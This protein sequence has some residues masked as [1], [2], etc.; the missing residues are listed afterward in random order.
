MVRLTK[1]GT[2]W[3]TFGMRLDAFVDQRAEERRKSV[4]SPQTA[5]QA[6]SA[7][8]EFGLWRKRGLLRSDLQYGAIWDGGIWI[9]EGRRGSGYN[10]VA[11]VNTNV[12]S[13]EI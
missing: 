1:H 4:L 5:A 8:M 11:R 6:I 2:L 9:V 3:T 10:A 7:V 12:N 13:E